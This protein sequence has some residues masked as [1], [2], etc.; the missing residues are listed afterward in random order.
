MI[1]TIADTVLANLLAIEVAERV[2]FGAPAGIHDRS[3]FV[4]RSSLV[5]S[6]AR[7]GVTLRLRGLRPS[8]TDLA[9]YAT[10]R[11]DTVRM[12]PTWSTAVLFQAWGTKRP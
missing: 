9:R 8:V 1:D 6:C 11:S 4:D 5:E 12:V 10:R 2:P 3:L 7:R